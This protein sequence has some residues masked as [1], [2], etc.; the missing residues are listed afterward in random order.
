MI[1]KLLL[2]VLMLAPLSLMAQKFAHFNSN[3]ILT[4]YPAAKAVQTELEALGKQYQSDLEAMQKELQTKVQKFEQE[5]NDKTPANM[6][7]RRQQELQELNQRIQQAYQDNEQAFR[8]ETQKKMQPVQKA[9]YDAIDAAL[10]AGGYTYGVD[11]ATVQGIT[12]NEALSTDITAQIKAQLG[13][14]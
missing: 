3:D 2:L 14:K 7:A 10:K 13:I 9:V 11:K 4:V 12:I 5:V 8:Q 6:R 1:K